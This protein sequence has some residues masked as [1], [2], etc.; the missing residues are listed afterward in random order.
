[1]LMMTA[2]AMRR[3]NRAL[4]TNGAEE[5]A[6]QRDVA[7]R[8]WL[9]VGCQRHHPAELEAPLRMKRAELRH[10]MQRPETEEFFRSE[11]LDLDLSTPGHS[12]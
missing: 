11:I 1:M 10:Q 6:A 7:A 2:V 5:S 4:S 9:V 8:L 3:E 12:K